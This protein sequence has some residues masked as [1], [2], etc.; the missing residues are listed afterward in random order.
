MFN[1]KPKDTAIIFGSGV[2]IN[3]HV[4]IIKE[5]TEKYCTIGLNNFPNKFADLYLENEKS[6]KT[7][8]WLVSDSCGFNT[9]VENYN[10]QQPIINI[11]HGE[12]VNIFRDNKIKI[13]PF[14]PV[15][16]PKEKFG[17]DLELCL[18]YSSVV[19][20]IDFLR[21]KGFTKIILF[22]IDNN[23]NQDDTWSHF[24]EDSNPC[25]KTLDQI[26]EI[27][28]QIQDLEKYVTIFTTEESELEKAFKIP[29]SNLVKLLDGTILIES[30]N[31]EDL[32]IV[33]EQNN[34]EK[35]P[36]I[37]KDIELSDDV[38]IELIVPNFL[39]RDA[40]IHLIDKIYKAV[41]GIV[42]VSETHADI[43]QTQG[44]KFNG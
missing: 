31:K 29:N 3:N 41:D 21:Q 38:L 20:A 35:L 32:I 4:E 42:V 5:L 18:G 23:I 40:E 2:S 28:L 22:G 27:D 16:E 34:S 30:D 17:R 14:K 25:D 19:S 36:P 10:K 24:Y 12:K 43:L 1:K 7:D 26:I 13:I 6:L 8:Y 44:Y 9:V 39:P 15:L 37:D 33:P 11:T